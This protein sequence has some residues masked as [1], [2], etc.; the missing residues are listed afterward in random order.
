MR[1]KSLALLMLALGCGLVASLG[2][3]QVMR[4]RGEATTA[5]G[6]T[7]PIFVAMKDVGQGEPLTP[8]SLKLE[9]WPK[10]KVPPGAMNHLE[11]IENRRTRTKLYAGEPILDAKLA[12]KGVNAPGADIMIPKGYRVVSIRVDAVS[13]GANLLLARLPR[14]HPRPH[15]EE[16]RGGNPRN[17]H[18]HHP[19]GH[20][21]LRRQRSGRTRAG[22]AGDQI[23]PG[24]NRLALGHPRPGGE[25]DAGDRDGHDQAGDAKSG[26]RHAD[27]DGGGPAAGV[28]RRVGQGGAEEARI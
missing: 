1:G 28:V 20:Q 4:K 19:P 18:P 7:Q 2:I 6:D 13:G 15:G 25:G 10:D 23:D 14:R 12:P 24:S 22:G 8:E 11:D 21:G 17:H 9:Q 5:T 16:S 26:G 3:T 27:G